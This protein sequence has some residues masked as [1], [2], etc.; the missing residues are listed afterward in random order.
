MNLDCLYTIK[1]DDWMDYGDGHTA[2][3]TKVSTWVTSLLN[4]FPLF[5]RPGFS[6]SNNFSEDFVSA[7]VHA[8]FFRLA[9]NGRTWGQDKC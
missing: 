5:S 6:G 2:F 3:Y 4:I 9:T 8:G 7:T 1:K